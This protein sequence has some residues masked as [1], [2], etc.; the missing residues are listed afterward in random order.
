MKSDKIATRFEKRELG[1]TL[2]E[3]A[4]EEGISRQAVQQSLAL[5]YGSSNFTTYLSP[6]RLGQL[7]RLSPETISKYRRDGIIKQVNTSRW[8]PLYGLDAIKAIRELRVCEVC[9]GF[10][11]GGRKTCCSPECMGIARKK[12]GARCLWRGFL[13]KKGLHIPPSVAYV[14]PS[15]AGVG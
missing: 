1:Y 13:I 14:K 6:L 2:D 12:A 7:L 15:L 8:R 4:V 9:G 5:T 11:T 3:I 10:V